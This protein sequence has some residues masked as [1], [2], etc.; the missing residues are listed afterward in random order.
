ME[1]SLTEQLQHF[2]GSDRRMA[3]D[4]ARRI[5]PELHRIAVRELYRERPYQPCSATELINEYW[6]RALQRGGWEFRN[7]AHF[8]AMA[9]L[10][11]RRVLVDLA[12]NRKAQRRGSGIVPESLDESRAHH[13]LAQDDSTLVELGMLMDLLDKERPDWARV[14]DMYYFAGF[15]LE[16]I[17]ETTELSL[18]QIRYRWEKG[19]DWLKDRLFGPDMG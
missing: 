15:T 13:N 16:E 19:R 2:G 18:K 3:N 7:R 17:A 12:R 6:L 1:A 10:V 9:A 11:M 4:L 14:V 5:L 8:F